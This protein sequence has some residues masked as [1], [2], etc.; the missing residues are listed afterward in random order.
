MM[1]PPFKLN[2]VHRYVQYSLEPGSPP[3]EKL[4]AW[5]GAGAGARR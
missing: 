4:F 3:R 2:I 1:E 5:M